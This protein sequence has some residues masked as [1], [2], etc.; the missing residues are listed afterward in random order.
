[1]GLTATFISLSTILSATSIA[2]AANAG[3]ILIE[4]FASPTHTWESLNDPVMG[5]ES[6]GTVK[7]ENELGVFDGE[8]VDVPFLNAPGFI[9][10]ETRDGSY[11]DVSSCNALKMVLMATEEYDGYRVSFGNVHLHGKRHAYGYKADFEAPVGSFDDIVIPFDDFSSDWSEYTG[12]QIMTCKE[13]SQYCPDKNTLQNMH[14]ISLWGEG[15]A[16]I[17]HL[18]I[19]SISAIG[20]A[21]FADAGKYFPRETT[22]LS[23]EKSFI[24]KYGLCAIAGV[25]L[26]AV[27]AVVLFNRSR[28]SLNYE[29][30][31]EGVIIV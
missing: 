6:T 20:C 30:I 26:I 14:T 27:A 22:S 4:S 3:D 24:P 5:G 1:M 25:G 2:I 28:R 16:G 18:Q 19:K 31:G 8:V 21:R 7:I 23:Q 9:T 10:M 12:D 17:V 11:P 15:V 13:D 29:R